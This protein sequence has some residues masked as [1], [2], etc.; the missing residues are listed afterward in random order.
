MKWDWMEGSDPSVHHH[1]HHHHHLSLPIF[2]SSCETN[3][4]WP[5]LRHLRSIYAKSE[6]SWM[7]NNTYYFSLATWPSDKRDPPHLIIVVPPVI[8]LEQLLWMISW[9]NTGRP[10]RQLNIIVLL[11]DKYLREI[12]YLYSV[13]PVCLCL[14]PANQLTI[15]P[16]YGKRNDVWVKRYE[17][18]RWDCCPTRQRYDRG[19]KWAL[20]ILP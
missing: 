7:R 15:K 6:S 18:S 1:H 14:L 12:L 8:F 19:G 4:F 2:V 16:R 13:Y 3:L 11:V 9:V 5:K 10:S 20:I 17:N